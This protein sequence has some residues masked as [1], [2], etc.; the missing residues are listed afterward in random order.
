MRDP[1]FA[2]GHIRGRHFGDQLCQLLGHWRPSFGSRFP[3]PEQP[4]PFP[5]P[6]DERVGLDDNQ[7]VLPVEQPREPCHR[8]PRGVV[9]T[10]RG[11]LP[12]DEERE[13]LSEEQI[14]RSEGGACAEEIA[15]EREGVDGD[16]APV[17]DCAKQPILAGLS[18]GFKGGST[19]C[20]H[21]ASLPSRR[22]PARLTG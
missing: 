1:L 20:G 18:R 14:L 22:K 19:F 17:L 5:V 3:P 16:A 11:A 4:K 12:L 21:Q 13:L 7:R 8:E 6:V 15:N 9:G 10:V 2:P